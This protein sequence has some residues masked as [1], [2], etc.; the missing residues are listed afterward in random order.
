MIYAKNVHCFFTLGLACMCPLTFI[1]TLL[2]NANVVIYFV[3]I[4]LQHY[5]DFFLEQ[6]MEW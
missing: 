4:A 2:N 5:F 6:R 1:T 3:V